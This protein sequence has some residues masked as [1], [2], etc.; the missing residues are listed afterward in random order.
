MRFQLHICVLFLTGCVGCGDP[1]A[2][3]EPDAEPSLPEACLFGGQA[4]D[5]ALQVGC[6]GDF[7]ALASRPLNTSIPG[8]RSAKVL[9]DRASGDTLYFMNT[10]T[11]PRHFDFASAELSDAP[12]PAVVDI[13]LFNQTEYRSPNRR[14]LLGA[15]TYYEGPAVWAYE[16]A[17]YDSS[18][19]EMV[20]LSMQ[21]IAR[22]SYF[23]G[24][25]CFH[26]TSVNTATVAASLPAQTCVV[27][28]DEIFADTD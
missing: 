26:P 4:P 25:L 16:I 19:A 20:A 12:L 17:P 3:P 2:D 5:F 14:F 11:Y 7:D 8:A 24:Q 15:V 27:T 23:G 6:R 21:L 1:A 18:S 10:N 9:V 13:S 28:T 22:N